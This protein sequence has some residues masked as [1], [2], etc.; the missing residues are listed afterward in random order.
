MKST[1]SLTPEGEVDA[2]VE[3]TSQVRVDV[4]AKKVYKIGNLSAVEDMSKPGRG[5]LEKNFQKFFDYLT[6]SKKGMT[7]FG[8]GMLMEE[9]IIIKLLILKIQEKVSQ[10]LDGLIL[11]KLKKLGM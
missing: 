11:T 1:L 8:V 2:R 10:T 6:L 5:K 7:F 9:F 3:S 4:I